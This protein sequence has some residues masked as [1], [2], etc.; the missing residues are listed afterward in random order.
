[1]RVALISAIT[2]SLSLVA[3]GLVLY[4][5]G[6]TVNTMILTGLVIALGVLVDDAI[7][8]VEN[9]VRR[10]R[11]H[12]LDGSTKSTASIILDASLEVRGPIVQAMM[13]ILVSTVPVFLLGGLTGAFFRPLAFAYGLAILA[14][15]LVALTVIPALALILLR[16]APIERRES[17]V[18]RLL[19]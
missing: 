1:W 13:I 17:P 14:S 7:I 3:A 9:I 16:N 19:H 8:N 4:W 15:L 12:R 6:A 10:I 18:V 2:I 5:T 11:Q